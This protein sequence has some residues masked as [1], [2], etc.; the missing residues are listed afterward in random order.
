MDALLAIAR[1]IPPLALGGAVL[2]AL[3][4]TWHAGR[5][6]TEYRPDVPR[7]R[8]G[9]PV[10]FL[11]S[12]PLGYALRTWFADDFTPAGKQSQRLLVL[13]P[14]LVVA[15]IAIALLASSAVNQLWPSDAIVPLA[16][17]ACVAVGAAWLSMRIVRT[18][19]AHTRLVRESKLERSLAIRR[20]ADGG[21]SNR[22]AAERAAW[23]IAPLGA[24]VT[25]GAR[26]AFQIM[27]P[28]TGLILLILFLN[29]GPVL[30]DDHGMVM[31]IGLLLFTYPL[32][33]AVS[34]AIIGLLLPLMRSVIGAVVCG[35]I[36][37][38]PWTAG[39]AVGIDHGLT[40]WNSVHSSMVVVMTVIFGSIVGLG[41]REIM[42]DHAHRRAKE[43]ARAR[44]RRHATARDGASEHE[45]DDVVAPDDGPEE[46]G[47][48][49]RLRCA[50]CGYPTLRAGGDGVCPLCDWENATGDASADDADRNDGLSLEQARQNFHRYLTVYDLTHPQ[51][52]MGS[53]PSAAERAAKQDMIH[54]F[55]AMAQRNDW[56]DVALW[57]RVI[58]GEDELSRAVDARVPT[59]E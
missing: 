39:V 48:F 45:G 26:L 23:S 5:L 31:N 34:G 38:I 24:R 29:G 37:L 40:S 56:N 4:G 21:L 20:P 59:R 44:R 30:V 50:C 43:D 15:L 42:D 7:S 53:G 13:Y 51:P 12:T 14:A 2:C 57:N 18:E 58:A 25:G 11:Y 6:M 33:A 17:L 46:I 16:L 19:I 27:L 1:R 8:R 28:F 3:L 22:S 52:W 36:A 47:P 10:G 32:G 9:I 49:H 54:A 55:K 41:T 35:L